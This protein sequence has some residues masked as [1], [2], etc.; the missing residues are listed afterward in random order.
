MVDLDP[1]DEEDMNDIKTNDLKA[2][3]LYRKHRCKIYFG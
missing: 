2:L 1:L 3:C